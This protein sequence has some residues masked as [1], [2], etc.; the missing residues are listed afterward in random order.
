MIRRRLKQAVGAAV[1]SLLAATSAAVVAEGPASAAGSCNGPGW[2]CF[3]DYN[4]AQYGN[5][6]GNNSNWGAFGWNDR[7]DWFYNQGNFCQ[8]TVYQNANYG[9]S[10]VT[11]PIG[12]TLT[13]YDTVSSNWW[14]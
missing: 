8:V 1:V 12:W 6:A 3:Y 11:I 10:S 7:A 2:L 5:V 14:C 13:W 4:T 9:G